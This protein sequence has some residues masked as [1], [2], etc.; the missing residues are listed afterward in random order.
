MDSRRQR[1]TLA[2]SGRNL[3]R[4]T[5]ELGTLQEAIKVVDDG[6][7]P[8]RPR[9]GNARQLRAR[10]HGSAAGG[11]IRPPKKLRDFAPT[12]PASLRGTG[13]DG[14]GRL[15]A[16]IGLDGYL[17]DIAVEGEAH[18]EFASAPSWPCA[19]GCLGDAPQTVSRS[20]VG[21]TIQ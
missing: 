10:M 13:T 5:R 11:Q 17:T 19:N 21:M 18:P 15:K 9:S 4:T 16:R 8:S 14:V 3:Q 6:R 20:F 12:Y 2:V 1:D 7:D